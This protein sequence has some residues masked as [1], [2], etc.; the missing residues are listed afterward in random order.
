[1]SD[2][3]NISINICNLD[4]FQ[5][6]SLFDPRQAAFDQFCVSREVL[7][8]G[9]LDGVP[10]WRIF[11]FNINKRLSS[12]VCWIVWPVCF[13]QCTVVVIV[14]YCFFL[15]YW[16]HLRRYLWW[17]AP[18]IT[19]WSTWQFNMTLPHLNPE[20]RKNPRKM[21]DRWILEQKH[22]QFFLIG[23]KHVS[24]TLGD[25]IVRFIKLCTGSR[26]FLFLW[27]PPILSSESESWEVPLILTID[28]QGRS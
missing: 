3:K 18:K 22:C 25:A 20:F 10:C 7:S 14:S 16:G 1:M 4:E 9:V 5:A 17:M 26:V 6:A 21:P 12:T 28:D 19:V 15:I 23:F 13:K 2:K 11:H 27:K 8:N 24:Y